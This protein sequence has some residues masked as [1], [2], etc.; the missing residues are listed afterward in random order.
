MADGKKSLQS[1]KNLWERK[2]NP[3]L[4]LSTGFA[5]A[6]VSSSPVLYRCDMHIMQVLSARQHVLYH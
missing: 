4:P 2:S 3:N 1:E 5:I 6:T